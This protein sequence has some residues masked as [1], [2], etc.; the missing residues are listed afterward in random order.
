MGPQLRSLLGDAHDQCVALTATTA[1]GGRAN[2]ATAT[3][4]LQGEVQRDAGPRHA[5]GVPD[6]DRASIDVDLV[7]VDAE[8]FGGR[9]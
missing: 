5:D 3:L 4:Q 9:Q 2:T 1:K 7:G 6:R 8:L